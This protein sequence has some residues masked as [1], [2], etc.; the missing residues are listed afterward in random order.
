[1]GRRRSGSASRAAE[2]VGPSL[3]VV[4]MP[5]FAA[6]P[7]PSRLRPPR[8]RLALVPRRSLCSRLSAG[9]APL[10]LVSAA[11]GW[12]KTTALAQWT[13]GEDRPVAWLRL[14]VADNDPVVLLACLVAVLAPVTGCDPHLADT[15]HVAAPPIWE[16]VVPSL[17][18]AVAAASPFLL[19]LDDAQ[20]VVGA[21]C[22]R[23][24]LALVDS[25]P[26]G[27]QIAVSTRVDPPLPLAR[28]RATGVLSAVG[29]ADLA[30]DRAETEELLALLDVALP[31]AGV[32]ALV[33]STEGWATGLSLAIA[34][35]RARRDEEPTT[36]VRGDLREIADY[37]LAEVFATQMPEVQSFLLQT[38][39][40]E[41]LSA[42][43]CLAVTERDDVHAILA[44]LASDNLFV[45]PEDDA[46]RWYRY[47]QLFA[48]FLRAELERRDPNSVPALCR[49]A[50]AWYLEQG[51]VPQAVVYLLEAGE[52]AARRG[53]RER[54][55][56]PL[57]GAWP[58]R[59]RP[60][61]A[62]VVQRRAGQAARPP[63]LDGWL[64]LLG[65]GRSRQGEAVDGGRL[66]RRRGRFAL[67]R[68]RLLVAL[69]AGL[70]AR[71]RRARWRRRHARRRG[72][73]GTAR[74]RPGL[75]LARGGAVPPGLRPVADGRRRPRRAASAGRGQGRG[76]Q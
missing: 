54:R 41:H 67:A 10:V 69:V 29:S 75:Q 62:A 50:G 5:P 46:G 19:V 72:A 40:L 37:L 55:V 17:A 35:V 16:T 4:E 70:A 3:A 71:R 74:A 53:H 33:R 1:M 48:D 25:L 22:W 13:A 49:R 44:H 14:D 64:G 63:G 15:L 57:L 34:A 56:D 9:D 45:T 73:C 36:V 28:L 31:T 66:S 60:A 39:V 12:G 76:R 52:Q 21:E 24:L 6:A 26:P 47:H 42:P 61:H 51:D 18:E 65:A 59:D 32:E 11:A 30:F 43:L 2:S 68:R 58:E 27:S 7:L 20:Q 23:I 8:L 38:A